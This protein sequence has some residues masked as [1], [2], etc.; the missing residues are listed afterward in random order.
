MRSFREIDFLLN[1]ADRRVVTQLLKM[2]KSESRSS[3]CRCK[4]V[5]KN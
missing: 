1:S 3:S 4:K 2:M 5:A